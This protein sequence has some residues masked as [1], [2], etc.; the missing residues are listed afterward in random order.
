MDTDKQFLRNIRTMN[1][2]ELRRF[3][4]DSEDI[5]TPDQNIFTADYNSTLKRG[6]GQQRELID[7]NI[8]TQNSVKELQT[9]RAALNRETKKYDVA[10]TV[11]IA[12]NLEPQ[13]EGKIDMKLN[14]DD[15]GGISFEERLFNEAGKSFNVFSDDYF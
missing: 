11:Q 15:D 12:S 14:Y 9:A 8:P 4:R 13:Y 5:L 3:Q 7:F 6:V 1:E 2:R 10:Q